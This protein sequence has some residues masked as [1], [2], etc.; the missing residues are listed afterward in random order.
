MK[1][2]TLWIA[3][4]LLALALPGPAIA[5]DEN[6]FLSMSVIDLAET[7]LLRNCGIEEEP[8]LEV[9]IVRHAG[10]LTPLFISAWEQGPAEELAKEVRDKARGRFDRNRATLEDADSLGLSPEDTKR[11]SDRTAEDF[12]N[13]SVQ[14]FETGYRGQALRGLYF[15]GGDESRRLLKQVAGEE[16]SAFSDTARLLLNRSRAE[17]ED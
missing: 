16:K 15:V 11:A 2:R 1:A 5:Q 6:R 7:W 4:T 13:R 8:L 9:A 12:V 14:S 17:S 10:E 3:V